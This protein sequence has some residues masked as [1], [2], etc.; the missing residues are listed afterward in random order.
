METRIVDLEGLVTSLEAA[1]QSL[2][3]SSQDIEQCFDRYGYFGD[4]RVSFEATSLLYQASNSSADLSI[5]MLDSW[6]AG[7]YP[8]TDASYANCSQCVLIQESSDKYFLADSGTLNI[9][10][11]DNTNFTGTLNGVKLVEVTIDGTTFD[12]APVPNGEIRCL[13]NYIFNAIP[14]SNP[15]I[16]EISPTVVNTYDGIAS[17]SVLGSGFIQGSAIALIEA[18]T[19]ISESFSATYISAG[20]LEFSFDAEFWTAGSYHI[21]VS[22]GI[23][24]E[25]TLND[26]LEIND[27][28]SCNF[29]CSP[30]IAQCP[31]EAY[32][33]SEPCTV[34]TCEALYCENP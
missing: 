9:T 5:E 19:G 1:I 11:P 26:A 18:A 22:N 33:S 14:C 23:D 28:A 16:S 15:T 13:D 30:S 2:Q 21:I 27:T 4:Q 10:S 25:A 7:T 17:I 12:S 20:E 34:I 29:C 3:D 32:C 24:C 6:T 8:I 31:I